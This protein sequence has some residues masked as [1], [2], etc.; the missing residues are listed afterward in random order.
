[1]ESPAYPLAVN[2]LAVASMSALSLSI[3]ALRTSVC[4][5][6]SMSS[7]PQRRAELTMSSKSRFSSLVYTTWVGFGVDSW[8]SGMR[9][10]K[11]TTG[12]PKVG[13]NIISGS[14][15][16]AVLKFQKSAT[17]TSPIRGSHF[18]HCTEF[19]PLLLDFGPTNPIQSSSVQ[20]SPA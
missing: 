15:E 6:C 19:W 16:I 12:L 17:N 20:F 3:S 5:A 13:P 7:L 10:S 2:S 1:M 14:Q 11:H 9:P 4:S 18:G 8:I